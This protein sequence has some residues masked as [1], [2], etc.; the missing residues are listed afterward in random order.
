MR[1]SDHAIPK[2]PWSG[3]IGARNIVMHTYDQLRPDLIREMVDV[4]VPRLLDQCR[5]I[6][7]ES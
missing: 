5:T 2:I 7:G 4:H 1:S 6:L 3:L